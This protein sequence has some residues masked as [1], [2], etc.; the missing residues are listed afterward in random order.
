ELMTKNT[1][2]NTRRV[3]LVGLISLALLVLVFTAVGVILLTKYK[4]VDT[5]SSAELSMPSI[6]LEEWLGG[7][8]YTKGF[9]GTWIS[10]DEILYQDWMDNLMIFN[11][12][13][14]RSRYVLNATNPVLGTSLD[15]QLSAD[16]K[17]LLLAFNYQRLYRHTY[18]ALYRII[19]LETL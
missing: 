18:L 4:D 8:L 6:S 5:P 13:S 17:F 15:R 9:N 11:V 14:R 7:E 10:G 12:S 1:G 16:R 2:C 19:N 3:L